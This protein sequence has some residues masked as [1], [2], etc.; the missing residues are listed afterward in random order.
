MFNKLKICNM[1]RISISTGLF[2]IAAYSIMS[3]V[4]AQGPLPCGNYKIDQEAEVK[5]M[6]F[7]LK[8][9]TPSEMEKSVAAN[10][11]NL[12]QTSAPIPVLVPMRIMLRILLRLMQI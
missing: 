9:Y 1:K 3:L 7:R 8:S 12:D 5:A 6:Q 4:S 11:F 2:V 10:Y